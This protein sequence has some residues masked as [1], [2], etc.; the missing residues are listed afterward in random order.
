MEA[1]VASTKIFKIPRKKVG[2]Y[3]INKVDETKALQT[4]NNT[5][6]LSLDRLS[7]AIFELIKIQSPSS[8]RTSVNANQDQ[9]L[10][11]SPRKRKAPDTTSTAKNYITLDDASSQDE[12]E[13]SNFIPNKLVLNYLYNKNKLNNL[14]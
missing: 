11:S 2:K 4:E 10:V 8:P 13:I 1:F 9:E 6:S 5:T 12:S 7:N 3:I 14:Y